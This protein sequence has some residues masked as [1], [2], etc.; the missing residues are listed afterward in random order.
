[1]HFFQKY[2][3]STMSWLNFDSRHTQHLYSTPAELNFKTEQMRIGHD[4]LFKSAAQESNE[5]NKDA[6]VYTSPAQHHQPSKCLQLIHESVPD[7]ELPF[8]PASDIAAATIRERCRL[9]IVIDDIVYDC[10]NFAEEHPGGATILEN[11]K[12]TDCTWQFWRFHS[13]NNL[14]TTGRGL[15]IGRTVGVGNRYQ[16]RPRYVGL[17][18][19]DSAQD[20]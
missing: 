2:L 1:M 3:D 4:K 10:T 8:I 9:L 16:R 5:G 20:W 7:H 17:A 15:R 14:Q 11:F 18:R 19:L 12:G 13:I 6:T